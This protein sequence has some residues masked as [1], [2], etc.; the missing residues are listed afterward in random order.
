MS[1]AA[2]VASAIEIRLPLPENLANSRLHWAAKDK[3]RAQYELACT[4]AAALQI[5][6]RPG[7]PWAHARITMRFRVH[8]L[9]DMDNLM[10]RAKWPCDWL[11]K[12]G[13]IAS[14]A[15][16]HLEWSG[17]PTQV[18]NRRDPGVTVT[19]EEV[20]TPVIPNPR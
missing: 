2:S 7:E 3:K 12:R 5:A 10:A 13:Y 15:P 17:L 1:R 11:R 6:P 19:L 18:I 4:V 8:N 16:K 9:L 20:T 14:D